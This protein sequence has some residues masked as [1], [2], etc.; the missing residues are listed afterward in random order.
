VRKI[1][2]SVLFTLAL[3]NSLLLSQVIR[4][5][6]NPYQGITL[7]SRSLNPPDFPRTV[8]LKVLKI[9]LTVP[10]IRFKLT[11]PAGNLEVINQTTLD[12]L[13]QE[14]AQFAVN[15][16]FYLPVGT[17][18]TNLIGLAASDGNV[19][20]GFEKPVQSYA[21]VD[22]APAINIDANNNAAVVHTDPSYPDGKHITE[23]VTLWNAVSGSAQIV[24]NGIKTIP[25]Y[26][27]T[28]HPEGLLTPDSRYSNDSPS[29]QNLGSWYEVINPRTAI[30]LSRDN[31]TL[32]ILTAD[33]RG[34]GGSWGL[35]GSEMADILINDYGVYSAL[36]L[37][38][39][40]STSIAMK[41]PATGAA[42]MINDSSDGPAGRAVGSS[43]AIFANPK[44]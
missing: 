32:I 9:D 12:F 29:G 27:D 28:S 13:L 1:A 23:K 41:D 15:V 37:D 18:E 36:N 5:I 33:G 40:G 42:R 35:T 6:E 20:S 11:P 17:R 14:K 38:G 30:G 10:G 39:G 16:H 34:A 2:L 7:I 24:T 22:Y 3:A 44:Q 4:T 25:Q 8:N 26:N 43:L 21:I 19:Y 31:R